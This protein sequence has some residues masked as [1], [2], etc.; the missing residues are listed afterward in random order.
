MVFNILGEDGESG[1]QG[2]TFK[3]SGN[4]EEGLLM[5][6]AVTLDCNGAHRPLKNQPRVGCKQL[7]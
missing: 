2:S 5:S 7:L 3:V 6:A 4:E 1:G